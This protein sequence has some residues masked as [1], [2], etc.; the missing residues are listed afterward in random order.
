V[1]KNLALATRILSDAAPG[2]KATAE[3][4]AKKAGSG[5]FTTPPAPKLVVNN[6]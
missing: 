1:L 5:R 2:K 6:T 3:E 4:I